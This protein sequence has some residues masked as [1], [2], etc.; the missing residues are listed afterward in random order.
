MKTLNSKGLTLV[1]VL[2]VIVILSIVST[3]LMSILV[4]SNDTNKKQLTKNQ[5]LDELSYVLKIITKD[6]RRT[7]EYNKP[8]FKTKDGSTQFTYLFDKTSNTITRNGEVIATNIKN[9]SINPE[10]SIDFIEIEIEN[11]NGHKVTTQLVFRSG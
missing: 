10:S 2:A 1:E 5:Q 7:S 6:T 4:S 9:F 3:I 11:N 8:T